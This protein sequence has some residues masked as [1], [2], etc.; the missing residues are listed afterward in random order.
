MLCYV[1][2]CYVRLSYVMLCYVTT[3]ISD[4]SWID[5]RAFT[6]IGLPANTDRP[7]NTSNH[8]NVF[9]GRFVLI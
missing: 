8:L 6:K 5:Y 3:L 9:I 2:L 4:K 7:C 1:M